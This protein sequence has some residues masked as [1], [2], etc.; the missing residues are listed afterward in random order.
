MPCIH[1]LDEINCPTCRII[2]STLPINS[3]KS[4]KSPA[5][6]IESPFFRSDNRLQDKVLKEITKNKMEIN[7]P[8]LNLIAK[9]TLLNEIPNFENKIL[10][11]RAKELDIS[12]DDNF[13][14]TKRISLENPE[15]KFEEEK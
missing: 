15:W 2:K 11:E 8:S 12:K 6:K 5:L 13:G 3:I 9:P 10:L 4:M 7:H 14:I 1:G